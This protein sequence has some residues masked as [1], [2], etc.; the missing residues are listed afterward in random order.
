[1]MSV[2]CA[3]R[4][5]TGA[6]HFDGPCR[7]FFGGPAPMFHAPTILDAGAI[8]CACGITVTPGHIH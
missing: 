8:L 2:T 7:C 5:S 6:R 3:A 1:M 4:P